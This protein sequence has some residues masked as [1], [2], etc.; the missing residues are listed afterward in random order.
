M[1]K[2]FVRF[3]FSLVLVLFIGLFFKGV[4][5][6]DWDDP[7]Y[8]KLELTSES[9]KTVV[10]KGDISKKEDITILKYSYPDSL[11][12]SDYEYIVWKSNITY[13]NNATEQVLAFADIECSF[14]YNAKNKT[15]ECLSSSCVKVCEDKSSL[16]SIFSRRKN[17]KLDLGGNFIDIKFKNQG[18]VYEESSYCLECDYLGNIS[19]NK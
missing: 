9:V 10:L 6:A 11:N 16:L 3:S 4:Y 18:I 1:M 12:T 19:L 17:N 2:K 7:S 8:G 13:F 15:C 5:A 14:K